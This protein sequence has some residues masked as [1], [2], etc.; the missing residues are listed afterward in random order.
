MDKHQLWQSVLGE[1]ELTISKANFTTWFK[2]T[3]IISYEEDTVIIGVPNTFTKAWLEKKFK[4]TIFDIIQKLTSFKVRKIE[5]KVEPKKREEPTAQPSQPKQQPNLQKAEI[6]KPT[7]KPEAEKKPNEHKPRFAKP[8]IIKP[9]F[10][11]SKNAHHE[12][13]EFS[14]NPKYHF[15]NFIVGKCN[16]LANAAA[17]AVAQNPGNAYNPLFIYGEVGL[18]K[19]HLLQAIGNEIKKSKPNS[20]ILYVSCEKFTSDFVKSIASKNVNSFKNKYR[21][22][23][24]LLMDDV[25]FLAGKESTQEEFFHTF[26]E[27]HQNNKQVVVT[28]D[29]PPKAIP[30]LEERLLSRFEWGMIADISTIDF[31]TRL[32]ILQIKSEEKN[33]NLAQETIEYIA[34][35]VHSNVRELEGALNRINA[36]VQLHNISP[37]LE[38]IKY[39]LGS[40]SSTPRDTE[41]ITTSRIISIVMDFFEI[42]KEDLLG[43]S[44][45]KNLVYPRQ[46][47]MYLIR[48]ELKAS[49][50]TIGREL[51]GRDHTTAMHACQKI[52]DKMQID[53]QIRRDLDRLKQKIYSRM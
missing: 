3:H 26:N 6:E 31:E 7:F 20:T 47:T 32:A 22:V 33:L 44:R 23:D 30:K 1:L 21:S 2:G 46:V 42:S 4:A 16:E 34:Q 35:T 8:D 19:T 45:Q 29:R 52:N 25:Q 15:R 41:N 11:I 24:L 5:Y 14:L 10:K 51:G 18:G 49:F 13:P 53:E 39:I 38:N 48:E 27:L 9:Q 28:S 50:P 36:H 12:L 37:T 40:M 43:K 17:K